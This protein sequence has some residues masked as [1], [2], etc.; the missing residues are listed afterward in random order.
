MGERALGGVEIKPHGRFY[1]YD[2]KYTEGRATHLM[3]APIHA[4]AYRDALAMALKAH[5]ALA[6]AACRGADLR[7]DDTAGEPGKLY[8]LEVN[9]QPGMTPLSLCR[10]S[11]RI[12]A[13][14]SRRWS[15]GWWRTPDASAGG[16]PPRRLGRRTAWPSRHAWT[17]RQPGAALVAADAGYPAAA[18]QRR[19]AGAQR[20]RRPGRRPR[21]RGLDV[22]RR[23]DLG[24]ARLVVEEVWITAARRPSRRNCWRRCR[25]SAHADPALRSGG[26]ARAVEA[27]GWVR[28]ASVRRSFPNEIVVQIVERKPMALWQHRGRMVLIGQDACDHQHNLGRFG[29]LLL[30]V[31]PTRRNTPP[32][33]STS[34]R[35]SP[36]WRSAWSA[37]R[38]SAVG[39]G[40]L[41]LDNG[42]EVQ[43]PEDGALGAWMRLAGARPRAGRVVARRQRAR[44]AAARPVGAPARPRRPARGAAEQGA[45]AWQRK[46]AGPGQ[47][48]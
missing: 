36:R 3:P 45:E 18:R 26:G 11:P 27:L 8:L 37:P 33:C 13:S 44:P 17:T 46:K 38:E 21:R 23:S 31:A 1:D 10:R 7:Y 9:T 35:P 24:R 2:A 40:N 34:W 15:T 19:L 30:L 22:R 48:T 20:C 39:A 42:V 4:E 12:R 29:N 6:A 43:L 25:S 41:K 14:A 16:V 32:S 47:N 28:D 5:Q